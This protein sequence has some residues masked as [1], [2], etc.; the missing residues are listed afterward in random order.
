MLLAPDG[1]VICE[2]WFVK[3][4]YMKIAVCFCLQAIREA[5]R[6]LEDDYTHQRLNIN[7]NVNNSLALQG[8]YAASRFAA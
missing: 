6:N 1:R 4:E 2:W 7:Q 5:N 3:N 8:Y